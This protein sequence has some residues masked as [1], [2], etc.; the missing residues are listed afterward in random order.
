M[1]FWCILHF[2]AAFGA[3]CSFEAFNLATLRLFLWLSH[4]LDMLLVV[5]VRVVVGVGV[6]V[7]DDVV[8][9][10]VVVV[11]AVVVPNLSA[12]TRSP[13]PSAGAGGFIFIQ[14]N[15]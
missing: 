9:D 7:V 15:I 6:E 14:A 2:L 5:V 12:L 8:D 4:V 13:L 11:V 3:S 10:D 1:H